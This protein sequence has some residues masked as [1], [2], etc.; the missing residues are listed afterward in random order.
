MAET[1]CTVCLKKLD[2]NE[3]GTFGYLPKETKS[4]QHIVCARCEE[5]IPKLA[6][7]KEECRIC[8]T[9]AHA[10][11]MAWNVWKQADTLWCLPCLLKTCKTQEETAKLKDIFGA[12][13]K[14]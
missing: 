6:T 2:T 11:G 3:A 5:W 1:K 9:G 13:K 7:M 4:Q 8:R 12:F 14:T 10:I